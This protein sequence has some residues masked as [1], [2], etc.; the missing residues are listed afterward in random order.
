MITQKHNP[1]N[2]PEPSPI[3]SDDTQPA[4]WDLVI[5]DFEF[6]F[7]GCQDYKDGI[8][9]LMR[10]RH[11]FGIKKYGVP[12]KVKNGRNF[13]NDSIQENLDILPYLKGILCEEKRSYQR[14][15]IEEA[16]RSA[17]ESII[18]LYEYFCLEEKK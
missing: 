1:A 12:L 2:T 15:L 11:R 14:W 8:L 4:L 16:Y 18:L 7:L 9:E 17:Q 10:N 3:N 13:L 6:G 5:A